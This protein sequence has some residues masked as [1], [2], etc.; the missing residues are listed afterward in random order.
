MVG[1]CWEEL[2]DR[3]EIFSLTVVFEAEWKDP[4]LSLSGLSMFGLSEGIFVT[5]SQASLGYLL[6]ECHFSYQ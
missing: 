2:C 5:I 6:N 3:R 4:S 1:H